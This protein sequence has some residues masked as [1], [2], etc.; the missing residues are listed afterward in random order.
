[1]IH[2]I[3]TVDDFLFSYYTENTEQKFYAHLSAAFDITTPSAITKF[4]ILSPTIYQS[5]YGTSLDQTSHIK[6]NIL[7]PWFDKGHLPK[8]VNSSF[9]TKTNS[10][11]DLSQSPPLEGDEL[12]KY[13]SRYHGAFNHSIGKLLHIQQWTCLDMNYTTTH[14]A[15]FARNPNKPVFIALE[16]L[17]RYKH[18]HL[19]EP[20]FYPNMSIDK[21]QKIKYIILPNNRQNI[22]FLHIQYSF[23]IHH[24]QNPTKLTTHAISLW[25]NEW[26]H[27]FLGLQIF[28]HPLWM[29]PLMQKFDPYIP[30]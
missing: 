3:Q 1:M 5:E 21:D 14:L 24:L 9:P 22:I 15:S 17:M 26:N 11:L 13:K 25:V 20:I 8:E 12:Q 23:Q 28:K 30:Q 27:N 6:S 4:K 10:E 2:F 19:H 18:S 16:H 29:I 7:A